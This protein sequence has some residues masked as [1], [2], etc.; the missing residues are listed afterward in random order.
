MKHVIKKFALLV[1]TI[2]LIFSASICFFRSSAN[3]KDEHFFCRVDGVLEY[4]GIPDLFKE[5][6]LIVEGT[7]SG[8]TDAFQIKSV[9]D[10]IAN[11]TDYHFDISSV[12]QGNLNSDTY[13]IDIRVEGG[14]VGNYTE[15]YTGSPSFEVG[16]DY[17]V[18]LYQPGRGGGFNTEGD[19]YYVLGLCQGVFSKDGNEEYISQSGETLSNDYFVLAISDDPND[20]DYFRDEYIENQKRNLDNGFISQDEFNQLMDNIDEYA[21]ILA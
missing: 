8:N 4:V 12:I 21:T 10:S 5:S 9:S 19:Y 7:I 15:E 3:P 11:F 1:L 13:S 2:A 20:P 6:T 17:L 18:F 16:K 14:T